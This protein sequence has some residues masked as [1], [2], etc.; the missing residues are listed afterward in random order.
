MVWHGCTDTRQPERVQ[1]ST[2]GH[3]P[4][5]T[6][7]D[8]KGE[9]F[10]L[11]NHRGKYVLLIF[12]TTWCPSCR[13]EIPRYKKI[14]ETFHRRGLDIV[15]INIQES[16]EK[17]SAFVAKHQIPYPTLLD[18]KGS[19]ASMFHIVGVPSLILISRDGKILSGDYM[20]MES[21]LETL[22]P[23]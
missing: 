20:I 4:D 11:S 3:S 13:A 21:I 12:V 19:V 9:T 6:L 15:S 2:S 14:H 18:E 5:F 1:K 23:G 17:V 8:V 7:K 10:T 22:M 16:R